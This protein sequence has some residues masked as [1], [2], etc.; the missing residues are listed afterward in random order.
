MRTIIRHQLL[1]IYAK[2]S[3]ELPPHDALHL[4]H[5]ARDIS[6]DLNPQNIIHMTAKDAMV[7]RTHFHELKLF[8][9]KNPTY[10]FYFW[11][12]D[13]INIFMTRYFSDHRIFKI[14]N[15]TPYGIIKADLFRLCVLYIYGGFYFDLK[16]QFAGDLQ[17]VGFTKDTLY[18]VQEKHPS[19]LN[20]PQLTH[21]AN[22]NIIANW[23]MAS[24]PRVT[25]VDNILNYIVDE[26]PQFETIQAEHGFVR[27][28]WETTGPRMLTRYFVDTNFKDNI[29]I[30]D[31]DDPSIV[32]T[33]SCQGAWVRGLV[34]KH[35]TTIK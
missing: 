2:V 21:H 28:V 18:L 31:H 34:S 26:F 35:Y 29:L 16:S 4:F 13:D 17:N 12:D 20:S 6:P 22:G 5:L 14:F 27:A 8:I 33:Y 9:E 10:H 15:D 19:P 24:M 25:T 30:F 32:P 23:F 7:G 3:G 11:N 1:N